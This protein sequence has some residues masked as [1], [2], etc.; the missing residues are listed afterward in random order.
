MIHGFCM[1]FI[2]SSF[3]IP[4]QMHAIW[5]QITFGL[6]RCLSTKEFAYHCRRCRRLGSIPGLERAP[7]GGNGNPLSILAWRIPWTEEPGRLGSV[8]RQRVGHNQTHVHTAQ[9]FAVGWSCTL[10]G[11]QQRPW[12]LP[13]RCHQHQPPPCSD[14][15]CL[16][17][18]RDQNCQCLRITD[19]QQSLFSS[20]TNELKLEENL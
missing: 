4:V 10:Q 8:G 7:G 9:L 12:S 20:G 17:S 18:F 16:V 13:T 5:G 3:S 14:H 6:P 11:V 15:N 19:L 1:G 2:Y